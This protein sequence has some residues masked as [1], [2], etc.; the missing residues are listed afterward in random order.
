MLCH[1][2]IPD[3]LIGVYRGELAAQAIVR[4]FREKRF[5]AA[6]FAAYE[7]AVRRGMKPFFRMIHKYYEP[8]FMEL[9]LNPSDRFGALDAVLSVLAGGFFQRMPWRR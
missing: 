9:F 5:T 1:L 4:A 7:R 8:A 6:G 3:S 2:P